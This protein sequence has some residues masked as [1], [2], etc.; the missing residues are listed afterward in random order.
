MKPSGPEF[1]FVGRF[2]FVCCL[3]FCFVG[4]FLIIDSISLFVI[5]LFRLC[6]FLIQSW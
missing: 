3:C 6:F 5:G 2:L 4:R 1:S